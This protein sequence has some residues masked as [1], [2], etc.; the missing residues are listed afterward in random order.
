MTD[1]LNPKA[2]AYVVLSV[3]D[4]PAAL[5]LWES[6]FGMQ[7]IVHRAG[8]DPGLARMWGV[9]DDEIVEQALLLTP[10][11]K[12]GGVHLVRFRT[13]GPIIRENAAATDLV[14]K[15]VDIAVRDI[16]TR[17]AE[18]QAA[19][20]KFRSSV[21]R[22]ETHGVVVHEVHLPGP[23]GINL[24]FLEEEGNPL[25]V[26]T[27]GYGVAPQIVATS[28]DNKQEKRFYEEV[29]GLAETSYHRFAGP[30]IERTIGLPPGAGLDIRIFG[31][32]DYPYGRLEIVQYEAA[33]SRN[34]Y[35]LA[36]APARGMLSVTFEVT[37]I[38]AMLER[39][40]AAASTVAPVD[41]GA[42]ETFYGKGRAASLWSPAGLRI[43]LWSPAP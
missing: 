26:S 17:H 41:H 35:P 33:Q 6:R 20:F 11:M 27:Q 31:D 4:F 43:D 40:R 36:K 9:A 28:P 5:A 34:L 39:A 19:G 12:Q 21:G 29:M 42:V 38:D 18:L 8:A 1:R 7:K 10:G 30:E 23:D 37:A 3:T 24:V 32:A 15:S 22:F 16:A 25:P 2:L 13:P 14:P